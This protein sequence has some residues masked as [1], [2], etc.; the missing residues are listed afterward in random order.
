MQAS[1]AII[2]IENLK[3][4]IAALRK[5]I[6]RRTRICLPVKADAYG[7]GAVEVSK[8]ALE[9]GVSMLAV[10]RLGE[11]ALLRDA[12]IN[13]PV[14]LFSQCVPE[15]LE[16]AARLRLIPF[17]S[18]REQAAEFSA[19]AKRA[20]VSGAEVFLKVDTGMGRLGCR[21]DEAVELARAILR[22]GLVIKGTATHL[23]ASD[24]DDEASVQYTRMQTSAFD[25]ALSALKA[26]GIDP[27]IVSAANSGAVL[28]RNFTSGS[29]VRPGILTYGYGGKA[30][31]EILPVLPVM[32]FVSR[33]VF[34]KK[35]KRGESVS[36]GRS[37][38]A[39]RDTY[40]G[41]LPAGYAD[42]LPRLLSDSGPSWS[43]RT[44][45]PFCVV[46]NGKSCPLAGR[47]CMDQCAIDL[48]PREPPPL[49]SDAVIFGGPPAENAAELAL[50][51]NTVPYEICCGISKRVPRV[52]LDVV[53]GAV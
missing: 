12:G 22:E 43:G 15:E 5:H 52:F 35:I 14:L 18:G 26:A 36:Y 9:C 21:P 45:K 6:G 20:G 33:L 7:H 8:A 48:G 29:L 2:H 46:I 23:A 40:I 4:N 49:Y 10:A 38:E 19:A 28:R 3:A 30:L 34:V 37:W 42:G 11:G 44:Q 24:A 51:V 17:I 41:I 31:T 13:A 16:E 1:R 50:R 53:A 27:G 25:A 47:I 39:R 32:E